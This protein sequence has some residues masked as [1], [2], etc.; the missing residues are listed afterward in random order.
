M[1]LQHVRETGSE[2]MGHAQRDATGLAPAPTALLALAEAA[3]QVSEGVGGV[4]HEVGSV[5]NTPSPSGPVGALAV[6]AAG[7][8]PAPVQMSRPLAIAAGRAT[9]ESED[10]DENRMSMLASRSPSND[11]RARAYR[12]ATPLFNNLLNHGSSTYALV[13]RDRRIEVD[14]CIDRNGRHISDEREIFE[15]STNGHYLTHHKDFRSLA[16]QIRE[17]DYMD[18]ELVRETM[19][20]C[21]Q[22]NAV[23][24]SWP[25]KEGQFH[26]DAVNPSTWMRET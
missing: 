19:E 14:S 16:K 6:V 26:A 4:D 25:W 13:P 5:V 12:A 17:E 3:G 1:S 15:G 21:Q 7:A 11:E 2:E 20:L 23:R 24:R 22:Q 8:N 18:F 10:W 9:F